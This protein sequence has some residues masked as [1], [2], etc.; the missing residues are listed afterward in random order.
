ME[1]ARLT[2]QGQLRIIGRS[3]RIGDNVRHSEWGGQPT[4]MG[5][6][7]LCKTTGEESVCFFHEGVLRCN[8]EVLGILSFYF[9]SGGSLGSGLT[10]TFVVPVT[11]SMECQRPEIDLPTLPTGMHFCSSL[12]T[13]VNYSNY[14]PVSQEAA[15]LPIFLFCT[16]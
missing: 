14:Y 6:Y 7:Y 2:G 9:E 3:S 16:T 12:T 13:H 5:M 10:S 4:C 15:Y 8:W 11:S 1:E